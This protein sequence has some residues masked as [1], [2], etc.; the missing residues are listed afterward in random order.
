MDDKALRRLEDKVEAWRRRVK[1]EDE[2][3]TYDEVFDR[4]TLVLLQRFISKGT[5]DTL[6][7][8]IATGKEGNVFRASG[9][10][11]ARAV[12]IYRVST[13]TYRA[14]TKYIEGDPRFLRVGGNRRKII[15]AW[16]QK[17]FKNLERMRQHGVRVPRPVTVRN[18][19]LVMEYLGSPEA[20]APELRRV[21]VDDPE[22]LYDLLLEDMRRIHR[23]ELVHG[24]LSEYNVL[25]WEG[26][27]WIID[28][29]QAV[30]LDHPQA[31]AWFRRDMEN[32]ARYFTRLLDRPMDADTLAE[33]V[34][35]D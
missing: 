24:D 2:R 35:E 32:M 11:G 4:S 10:E 21:T 16:A 15:F 29:G 27:P 1:D 8:P 25:V 7:F 14:L 23:A 19:V 3:K 12:K 9:E 17:E 30:H 13:A 31:E 22:A 6:D 33:R 18:N 5:F 28:V 20:P 26:A 34:R